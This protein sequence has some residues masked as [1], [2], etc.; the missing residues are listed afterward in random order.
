MRVESTPRTRYFTP[1]EA[2]ALLPEVSKLM[3]NAAERGRRLKQIVEGLGEGK[4]V[5]EPERAELVKE[6][7]RLRG[8]V[9]QL[10]ERMN[11]LGV[12][13]KGLDTGLVDFPA[14]RNG[15]EVY[16]CWRLGE[17]KIEWWHPLTTGYAGRQKVATSERVR[18]EWCN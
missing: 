15:E 9:T 16:L 11:E 14:L 5:S 7:E 17:A 18:W 1:A 4:P 13:V 3:G 8:E 12:D 6:V 10:V 2:T